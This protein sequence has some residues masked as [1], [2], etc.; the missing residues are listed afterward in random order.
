MAKYLK[1]K[2]LKSDEMTTGGDYLMKSIKVLQLVS[3][4]LEQKLIND[5]ANTLLKHTRE[6]YLTQLK[7]AYVTKHTSYTG[8][9]D[10]R[11]FYTDWVARL[12]EYASNGIR[13]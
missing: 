3:E 4:G 12:T 8:L 10:V 7:D 6:Q 11:A 5:E 9:V 2:Q 13:L 1:A